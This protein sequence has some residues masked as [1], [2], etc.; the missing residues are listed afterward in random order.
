MR[1]AGLLLIFVLALLGKVFAYQTEYVTDIGLSSKTTLLTGLPG[2]E[3]LAASGLSNSVFIMDSSTS[4]IKNTIT[5]DFSPSMIGVDEKRARALVLSNTGDLAFIDLATGV[6]SSKQMIQS[7]VNALAID[8]AADSFY[9]GTSDGISIMNLETGQPIS[10]INLPFEVSHINLSTNGLIVSGEIPNSNGSSLE[11]LDT[12]TWQGAAISNCTGVITNIGSDDGLGIIITIQKGG[13]L[14]I[15]DDNLNLINSLPACESTLG[16]CEIEGFSLNPE[17]HIGIVSE[18]NSLVRILSLNAGS[19]LIDERLSDIPGPNYI[20]FSQNTAYLAHQTGIAVVQLE[21]P[22]PIINGLVPSSARVGDAGF[23]LSIQGANFLKQSQTSFDNENIPTS[24]SQSTLLQGQLPSCDLTTPGDMPVQVG[25]PPPGGG[26]SNTYIFKVYNP[27]PVMNSISP[28]IVSRGISFTLNVRGR[29]F[30]NGSRIN[31]NGQYLQTRFISSILLQADVDG[32]LTGQDGGYPIVVINPAPGSYTSN[33]AFLSV[34]ENA[35]IVQTPTSSNSPLTNAVG[36]GTLRGRILNTD[37]SPLAGVTIKA[38]NSSVTTDSNGEFTIDNVPAG[39]ALILVDGS[40]VTGAHYPTIPLTIDILAN[41]PS[42]MPFQIYLHK[43]KTTNFAAITP[44]ADTVLSDPELPGFELR[45]PKGDRIIGWDSQPNKKISVRVVPP[46]RL[47]VKPLPPNSFVRTVH[48]FYFGKTGGGTP[49]QP[50]PVKARNDLNLRPGEKAVLWYYDESPIEG[51]APND[52]AVAGTGTVTSDGKYIVSDPGVGIPKFCCG[53]TAYG[54]TP[55][56]SPASS[57]ADSGSPDNSG[58][59]GNPGNPSNPGNPG[60]PNNTPEPVNIGTG[61]FLDEKTDYYIPGVIPLKITRTY[62]SGDS[63]AGAFGK[64]TYFGYDMW[65]QTSGLSNSV[66]LLMPGNYQYSFALQPNGTYMD[67]S[68]PAYIGDVITNNGFNYVLKRKNGWSYTFSPNLLSKIVDPNG[69]TMQFLAQVDGN[70]STIILPDGRTVT[71]NYVI[72]GRDN[73]TSITGPLGTVNYSYYSMGATGQLKSV[74]YPDG[75]TT[76]YDY[77]SSGNM[78]HVYKNGNLEVSN[79]YD[80]N[81]RVI[82]QTLADGAT[83]TFNYTLAGGNITQTS[84]TAPNGGVTTWRFYDNTGYYY[85]GYIVMVNTPDGTTTYNR[86]PGTNLITSK[87]D[88]LGG[89]ISYTYDSEGRISSL[90]DPS[91]NATSF[92]QY[93]NT[94]SKVTK[95]TDALND[96]TNYSYDSKCNLLQTNSPMNKITNLTYTS[97][98]LVNSI[99]DPLNNTIIFSYDSSGNLIKKTDPLGNMTSFTFD[100]SG[101]P[102]TMTNPN[103]KTYS[104]TY[105]YW[106]K[107]TQVQDPLGNVTSYSYDLN[108]NLVSFTDA[109][110]RLT[111]YVY[112]SKDRLIKTID[113]L[114]RYETYSYDTSDN[115]ISFT[116]RKGQTSTYQYDPM[117]R[118]IKATYADASYITYTYDAGGRLTDANDSVTGNVHFDYATNICPSCSSGLTNRIIKETNPLGSISY[119]YDAIDRRTGMTVTGQPQVAYAY[120]NDSRLTTITGIVN[121]TIRNFL[122]SHNSDGMRSALQSP[123]YQSGSYLTTNATYDNASRLL[124]LKHTVSSTVLEDLRYMRDPNGNTISYTRNAAQLLS[125]VVTG[126]TYDDAN[127][128]LTFTPSGDSSGS[129][130]Y[131]ADGNLL[132]RTNSCGTTNYTWDARNRLIGLTGY[133]PTCTVLTASFQYDAL[134]RRIGKMING[135]TTQYL[136]DGLDIIQEI[137]NGA[138]YANYIRTLN[139]D[140]PLV[141]IKADGTIRHYRADA[142]GSI[143]ALTDDNGTVMTSY[144]YDPF[145]NVTVSGEA[146]DNPFQYAGRENDGTGLYYYRERYYSPELQRFASEDPI[147]LFGGANKYVYVLNNPLLLNDPLGLCGSKWLGLAMMGQGAANFLL[148]VGLEYIAFTEDET[149]IGAVEGAHAAT[150]GIGFMWGGGMEFYAGWNTFNYGNPLGK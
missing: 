93:E 50:I 12:Q 120:D 28:S 77:D 141:R 108:G 25:N 132:A 150:L 112:D 119:T 107:L 128:M 133:T 44:S 80:A 76:S 42:Y 113:P 67:S 117:N 68:D 130:T 32:S 17:T 127:E 111:N 118:L 149:I 86:Q 99:T 52:W 34:V 137:Q 136:Y 146:L 53:A 4:Q 16:P 114:G 23:T 96:A 6:I 138:P 10:N 59:P 79:Q 58:N 36:S 134:G 56:G 116:D 124:E 14:N 29:N 84:M 51:Q 43:Q 109:M 35:Q 33:P 126:A 131:D 123:L 15:Y 2:G 145:G 30:F 65:L 66:L 104:Y 47:P 19:F 148:G 143:I 18:S 46:D 92:Y 22:V 94:C 49:D 100:G 121:G 60:P 55:L 97:A 105:N 31:L 71:I 85:N 135:V 38:R 101:R 139:I 129:L 72:L 62:R 144:T 142:L 83:Y 88:P 26:S 37:L 27:A 122:L 7:T 5:L 98:G 3:V 39:K 45:I 87:I 82:Q 69:N 9:L 110:G 64:G 40:S 75:S 73:I 21:N 57:P 125:G 70:I 89:T 74:Q 20:D 102:I 106:G 81:Y 8:K 13:K 147:G 103:G 78:A 115:L 54:G 11:I 95:F 90:T 140:E 63:G 1:K 48:M 41:T 24:Y 91:S 61:Y